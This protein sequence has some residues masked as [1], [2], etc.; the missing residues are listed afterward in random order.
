LTGESAY[1]RAAG[2]CA[3]LAAVG[4]LLYSVTFVF[5]KPDVPHGH[6]RHDAQSRGR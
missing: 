1:L 3:I 2:V 4:G 6:G 5:V